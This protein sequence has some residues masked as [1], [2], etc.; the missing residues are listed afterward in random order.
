SSEPLRLTR[1][2]ELPGATI[3]PDYENKTF[4]FS[5]AIVGVYYVQYQVSSGA[6]G[7]PGL[8]R[9]DVIEA[10][11]EDLPLVA[12]RDVA[13]LPTGGDVL[14]G[15]MNNDSDPSGGILVVQSVTVAPG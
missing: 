2:K 1:V 15:V 11:E 7:V 9:I 12:V 4:T 8:V 6:N 5:S 13:L 14:V 3:L 10:V